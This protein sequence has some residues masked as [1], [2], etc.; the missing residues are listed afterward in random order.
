[1]LSCPLY[2]AELGGKVGCAVG[3]SVALFECDVT[4]PVGDL[5]ITFELRYVDQWFG[6]L[7]TDTD[8]LYSSRWDF[9]EGTVGVFRSRLLWRFGDT[10]TT[11]NDGNFRNVG[12]WKFHF[13]LLLE[14]NVGRWS[15]GGKFVDEKLRI[16]LGD[17]R[18]KRVESREVGI[19]DANS[20]LGLWL[21]R[22]WKLDTIE[23]CVAVLV[24]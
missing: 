14:S 17:V 15:V 10:T 7:V 4:A 8:R 5:N 24:R 19:I 21:E 13:S 18:W 22:V 20:L 6:K 16:G 12:G 2:T 3:E 9:A 11:W 1:M 23:L